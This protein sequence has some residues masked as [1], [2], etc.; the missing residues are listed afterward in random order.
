MDKELNSFEVD[1]IEFISER[2]NRPKGEVETLFRQVRENLG[3]FKSKRFLQSDGTMQ[4]ICRLF[5]NTTSEEKTLDTYRF[6]APIHLLV[7]LS[8]AYPTKFSKRM[9]N[10]WRLFKSGEYGQIFQFGGKYLKSKVKKEGTVDLLLKHYPNP[11]VVVDYGCG[12]AH[13]SSEIARR[14]PS[15]Q[16][17]LVD[18]ESIILEFT[19]FRFKKYKYNFEVIKIEKGNLYPSLPEHTICLANEVMEHVFQPLTVYNNIHRAMMNGGL[20]F[21][22]F[23][24]HSSGLLHVTPDLSELRAKISESYEPV[25]TKIYRK[26]R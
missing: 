6:L 8:Y 7:F 23:S 19:I 12:M 16:I 5:L 1:L 11:S 4:Q 3:Y 14:N 13:F 18:I 26:V 15:T 9:S 10:A 2:E 22:N 20:L 24:D 17:Y 25:G 21:G